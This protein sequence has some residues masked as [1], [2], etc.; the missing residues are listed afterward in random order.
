MANILIIG[1]SRGI[2]EGFS[3]GLPDEGDRVWLV[4][5]SRPEA[6]DEDDGVEREWLE[7]DVAES[8]SGEEI[9]EWIGDETVDVAIY[10]AG[11]WEAG[12]FEPEYDFDQAPEDESWHIIEVNLGAAI[13]CIQAVLPHLRRSE[14]A[15][16]ILI[17][18]AAGL[19]NTGLLEVAYTASKFGIRGLAQALRENL[20]WD[21]I[22]VT[23]INPGEVANEIPYAEG[24][25]AA[26]EAYDNARIPIQDIVDL[27]RCVIDL[28]PAAC[29]KEINIPAMTD[30]Y[31]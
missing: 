29:V 28:S 2:G 3:L 31:A 5:R 20:R 25:E 15:R 6:L 18:S 22:G 9:A 13:T 11:I 12:G 19:E 17:G 8:G 30:E 21:R 26:L 7:L 10:N 4:S 23:C 16:I 24:A 1:G 27:V 14:K